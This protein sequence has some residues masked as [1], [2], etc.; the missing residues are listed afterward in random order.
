D[1]LKTMGRKSNVAKKFLKLAV[2]IICLTGFLLQTLEFLFLYWTYPTVVDIQV[3]VPSDIEMPGISLCSHNGFKPDVVCK[4]RG[5]CTMPRM[6]N[7]I[8][9]CAPF[10][11]VCGSHG[12]PP[13]D[14]RAVSV[15][16]FMSQ[17]D[18][19]QTV[20]DMLRIPLKDFFKCKITS[21]AQKRDCDMDNVIYGSYYSDSKILNFCFTLNS[22]W[23]DP[24]RKIQK[25]KKSEKIEMEFYMDISNR[26]T[27]APPDLPQRPKYNYPGSPA[28]QLAIHSPYLTVNPFV[29]GQGFL[30]GKRYQIKVKQDEKHL[31]PPPYQ[32][33]CTDYMPLWLARGGVGPLNQIM[34]IEECKLN[35][36]IEEMGCV[37]FSV[38]YPHNETV[39]R[40][41]ETYP[42]MSRIGE[43][44]TELLQYYN[45]PCDF[46]TYDMQIE[47][48]L[49]YVEKVLES[50]MM[51][52]KESLTF[53]EKG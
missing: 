16:G 29:S 33:N 48:K 8:D 36:T 47:E 27:D 21:G 22:L 17:N 6:F 49:V 53:K 13:E 52:V 5:W 20:L 3:S 38:D 45:Q 31:L 41:A 46:I 12:K 30:A 50:R 4:L 25:I 14:F 9:L 35:A 32:T 2:V 26:D 37:P 34:V 39:C 23:S 11:I 19:N 42:N 18:L 10:P 24:T 44:C 40:Y 1:T 15:H 7:F 43:I 28:V 51:R